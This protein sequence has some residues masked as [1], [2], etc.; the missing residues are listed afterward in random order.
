MPETPP[1]AG[2]VARVVRLLEGRAR[3]SE[4][5]VR[6]CPDPRVLDSFSPTRRA[7]SDAPCLGAAWAT[8]PAVGAILGAER[9]RQ[10][11]SAAAAC[12]RIVRSV[13]SPGQGAPRS[14]LKCL[15]PFCGPGNYKR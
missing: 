14:L 12:W 11:S 6:D 13:R 1:T 4:R 10:L 7:R 9:A 2:R 8:R 5:A 15:L 3:L